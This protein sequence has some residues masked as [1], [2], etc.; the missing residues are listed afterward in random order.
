MS[1]NKDINFFIYGAIAIIIG[2][3]LFPVVSTFVNE[4]SGDW[5]NVTQTYDDDTNVTGISGLE[6][7]IQ[8]IAYGFAFGL[9]GLGVGMIVY[10][11]KKM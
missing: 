5:N 3:I 6:N 11:F 10:G 1:N 8:L 7:V 2:L 4:A 9:V